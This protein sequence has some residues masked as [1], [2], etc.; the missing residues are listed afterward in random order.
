[1]NKN[2]E[3]AWEIEEVEI[4]KPVGTVISVRFPS[5]TA[6]RV[7]AEAERRSI[8]VSVVVREAVEDYLAGAVATPAFFDITVSSDAPVTLVSGR[9]AHGRT[10][11]APSDF[12]GARE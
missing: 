10:A 1:M 7:F 11:S 4:S 6:E 8:P 2:D 9:S 5:E 12:V 3:Q